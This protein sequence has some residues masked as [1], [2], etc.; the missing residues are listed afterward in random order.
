S[1]TV[2]F[3]ST[4]YCRATLA[5]LRLAAV[6]VFTT[7]CETPV[8][9]LV[10]RVPDLLYDTST[11]AAT[12]TYLWSNTSDAYLMQMRS[13][14]GLAEIA[15]GNT[16]LAKI[17]AVTRWTHGRFK[18]DGSNAS[19]FADPMGILDEAAQ[20]KRM[21][22]VEY[23]AVVSGALTSV[24]IPARSVWLLLADEA[25]RG[26]A[27]AHVVAEAWVAELGRWVMVDAQWD[28]IPT[29][30]GIPVSVLELQR[31]LARRDPR[32]QV[33]TS[34]GTS[35]TS[36]LAWV[37]PYLHYLLSPV[38]ARVGVTRAPGYVILAP[39]GDRSLANKYPPPSLITHHIRTFY[40]QL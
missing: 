7:A 9:P 1:L 18:H 31:A 35:S 10:Y 16:T 2:T 3:V 12:P 19:R 40:P 21:R 22:C 23:A 24:G 39:S 38:D 30:D 33:L 20:G 5:A 25:T 17:V 6:A 14:H 26:D 11:E 27:V 36:Y 8:Q 4:S 32:A 15:G 37:A 29:V 28:A 13:R 34:S